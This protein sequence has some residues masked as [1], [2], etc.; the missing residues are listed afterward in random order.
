MTRQGIR[1]AAGTLS[2][3]GMALLVVG[4]FLP[5]IIRIDYLAHAHCPN[6]PGCPPPT[7]DAYSLWQWLTANFALSVPS[8]WLALGETI[9]PLLLVLLLQLGIGLAALR[10]RGSRLLC[11]L[12]LLFALG[13][14]TFYLLLARVFYCLFYCGTG[15]FTAPGVRILAPGFWLLLAGFI[16]AVVSDLALLIMGGGGRPRG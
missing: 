1:R 14:G 13:L 10:G 9:G 6:G 4:L 8:S 15:L 12:G 2:L 5:W 3:A 16:G 7:R 11:A